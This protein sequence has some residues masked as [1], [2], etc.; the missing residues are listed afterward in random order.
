MCVFDA[1]QL[2]VVL[3]V[4]FIAYALQV[5]YRPYLSPSERNDVLR[6]HV[7]KSLRGGLHARLAERVK[8]AEAHGKK[9]ARNTKMTA[10]KESGP[11][12]MFANAILAYFFNYNTVEMTLLFCC[13]LIA[14]G[15]IMFESDRFQDASFQSQKDFITAIL[16]IVIIGSVIYCTL[17]AAAP[18]ASAAVAMIVLRVVCLCVVLSDLSNVLPFLPTPHY[19][20]I[21]RRCGDVGGAQADEG[22]SGAQGGGQGDEEGGAAAHHCTHCWGPED[23]RGCDGTVRQGTRCC[24]TGTGT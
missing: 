3:L 11:G 14:L 2:A 8:A 13:V 12:V 1:A 16:I 22:S 18:C 19:S 4:M 7:Y 6:E 5:R 24:H 23:I 17:P 21:C 10:S 9:A 15:G 20:R